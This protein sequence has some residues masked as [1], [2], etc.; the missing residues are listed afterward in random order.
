MYNNP[1]SSLALLGLLVGIGLL[2]PT[3]LSQVALWQR[4]EYR[5]DR[6]RAHITTP[7]AALAKHLWLLAAA[8]LVA[9]AWLIYIFMPTL[10]AIEALAGLALL[11]YAA[12]HVARLK[13]IGLMR[14]KWTLKSTA[15]L[16]ASALLVIAFFSW[17]FVPQE[18]PLLQVATLNFLLPALVAAALPVVNF[19]FYVRKMQTVRAAMAHRASLRHLQVVGIT[20]S[21]G[22]TSTKHFLQ[23]LVS[24]TDK[25]IAATPKHCNSYYGVALD[26]LHHVTAE[27]D[28]YIVEAGAYR[29]GEIRQITD[30][31][32]PNIGVLTVIGN[33]H[34]HLFGSRHDILS[35]KWELAESLPPD[36]TLVINKD[37]PLLIERA[38]I[39]RGK[40]VTF[41]TQQAADVYLTATT[42]GPTSISGTVH[43]GGQSAQVTIPLASPAL[44]SSLAAALAAAYA[45]EVPMSVILAQVTTLTA[46]DRTMEVKPGLHGATIIDD[47]YSAGE[48]PVKNA[49]EHL[50]RFAVPD[51]RIAMV[52]LIELGEDAK[53]VH[54][55]I[56]RTLQE[57][58]ARVYI[59]GQAHQK[60]IQEGAARAHITW[61]TN[62][63]AFARALTK[64]LS[65]SSVVLLEG[66][67]PA[68]SR[69]QLLQL[70]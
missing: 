67:I 5:L 40:V 25:T 30:I 63:H 15:T 7:E 10:G 41:S 64:G 65:A 19:A 48:L 4:K 8:G 57:S 22:K 35:T 46:F 43:L 44:L 18:V 51:K 21:Y 2:A 59:Y 26:M 37:D 9:F 13:R 28:I 39:F 32:K 61:Y 11:G 52:P 27:T 24:G 33:Q 42:I 70:P 34:L 6:M 1:M 69:Q 36:G 50:A 20:G 38:Q 68:L 62:P 60:D 45:L 29:R 3:L 31:V 16:V 14:P 12:H 23:H 55:E 53:R 66:R 54:R 56:G 17:M 58:N 49:I 47:S